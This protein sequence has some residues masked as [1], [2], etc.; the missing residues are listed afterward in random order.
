MAR[1]WQADASVGN[2]DGVYD[3]G[4]T[5]GDGSQV[6][7][8]PAEIAEAIS[9]YLESWTDEEIEVAKYGTSRFFVRFDVMVLP[10]E[11]RTAT[12]PAPKNFLP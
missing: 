10:V 6:S 12:D 2:L 8:T 11:K 4:Y 9:K 7:G 1:E 5:F 3:A